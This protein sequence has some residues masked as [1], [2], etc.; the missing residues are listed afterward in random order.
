MKYID[1]NV[2]VT[3]NVILKYIDYFLEMNVSFN[4]SY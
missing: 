4:G 2:K 1:R 3:K